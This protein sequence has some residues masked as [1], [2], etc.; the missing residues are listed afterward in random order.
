MPCRLISI[1]A[2]SPRKTS[3]RRHAEK[4]VDAV[5][6][7]ATDL[8][9]VG[10]MAFGSDVRMI[11]FAVPSGGAEFSAAAFAFAFA[12][13]FAAAQSVISGERMEQPA[14]VA[15]MRRACQMPAYQA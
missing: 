10:F 15:R 8:S 11:V 14:S 2:R 7:E 6:R 12:F 4:C 13:D 9:G 1:C 5:A 3:P